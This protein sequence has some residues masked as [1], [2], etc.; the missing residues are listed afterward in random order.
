[1]TFV[2]CEKEEF[3][4]EITEAELE[5]NWHITTKDIL[6]KEKPKWVQEAL[7]R[8]LRASASRARDFGFLASHE[9]LRIRMVMSKNGSLVMHA[10]V[11]ESL[12]GTKVHVQE[13][14]LADFYREMGCTME[15]SSLDPL[16]DYISKV[17]AIFE[18]NHCLLVSLH[19]KREKYLLN[20]MFMPMRDDCDYGVEVVIRAGMEYA[21]SITYKPALIQALFASM[22]YLVGPEDIGKLALWHS[23]HA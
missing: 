17:N 15:F 12:H 5:D 11:D 21:D 20:I 2:K 8:M 23:G 4:C 22:D 18:K 16:S 1:M 3:V 13:T 7:D 9:N 10:R 14:H 6:A 19:V